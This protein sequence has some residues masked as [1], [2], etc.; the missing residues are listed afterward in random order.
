VIRA[1]AA[2]IYDALAP[3][4]SAYFPVA[5]LE[6]SLD[7]G[8]RGFSVAGLPLRTRSKRV[9]E[10]ICEVLGYPVPKSFKRV[11]ATARF[12][13]QDF[14]VY[15]QSADNLQ[16]WNATLSPTRRYVLV[17]ESRGRL[18]RVRVVSGADLAK[19]DTTGTLTQ[20]YQ[21]RFVRAKEPGELVS[22]LDTDSL[23]TALARKIPR[24]ITAAPVAAPV[25]GSLLPIAELWRRLNAA[26]GRRFPDTGA[27][28]ERNRGASLHRLVCDVLGF[29]N[30][31]DD[32][33]F[34]DVRNQLLE[35]KLQ[36]AATI[37]LGLVAPDSEAP[38]DLGEFGAPR[39]RHC[40]VRYALF[41]A[42]T[43]GVSVQLTGLYLTTGRDF[44]RRFPRCEGKVL[45]RKLQ[46]KLPKGFL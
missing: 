5:E 23:Q 10:R 38:L 27:N 6:A 13:A 9:K 26:V 8:L 28:Q 25:S 19:L 44:F 17:R 32:G 18:V 42:R 24:R 35:V 20:K 4:L 46:L 22:V 33:R 39:V 45:N 29:P 37:D 15:V 31:A 2:T 21:A 30:Y 14:D 1:S 11:K 3:G 40:D 41:S 36:T 12:P 43:D 16:I 34:P 7:E